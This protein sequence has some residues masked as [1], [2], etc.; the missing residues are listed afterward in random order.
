M[1]SHLVTLDLP[2]DLAERAEALAKESHR[3]VE[4][5]L[6]EWLDRVA[7]ET[8]IEALS[9]DEVLTL[10]TLE[11]TDEEQ[12]RLSELLAAQRENQLDAAQRAQLD[13]LLDVYRRGMVQRSHALK[14]AVERGLLPPVAYC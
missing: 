10:S 13:R 1:M 11:M 5:V 9:D 6:L 2:H 14:V 8:P 12:E 4:D 7:K 3:R